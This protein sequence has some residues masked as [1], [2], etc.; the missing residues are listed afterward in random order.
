MAIW[1]PKTVGKEETE[2]G[3][4]TDRKKPANCQFEKKRKK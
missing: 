3:K 1:T 2:D 4:K